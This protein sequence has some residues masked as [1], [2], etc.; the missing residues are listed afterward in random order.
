MSER[1]E[2]ERQSSERENERETMSVK[3]SGEEEYKSFVK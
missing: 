2:R 1:R 3:E